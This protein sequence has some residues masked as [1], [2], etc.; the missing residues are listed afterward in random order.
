MNPTENVPVDAPPESETAPL[1]VWAFALSLAIL[2]ALA[3]FLIDERFGM[4]FIPESNMVT[5][6]GSQQNIPTIPATHRAE[7][8]NAML[9]YGIFGGVLALALGVAGGLARRSSASALRGGVVGLILGSVAAPVATA[10]LVPIYHRMLNTTPEEE[11]TNITLPL[12]VH[13]GIWA[14]IGTAAGMA[15]AI[16][17]EDRARILSTILGGLFGGV[18]GASIYEIVGTLV[19]LRGTTQS[20]SP[21]WPM[22]LIAVLT[23]SLFVAVLGAYGAVSAKPKRP[24]PK[25]AATV[26][27]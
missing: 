13:C 5:I 27:I 16:G 10:V 22:R 14:A 1:S 11:S 3:A 20:I 24:A 19:F 17:L 26:P 21:E 25:P 12:L 23:A 18:V 15:L 2:G 7:R 6:M 4:R 9:A 8:K